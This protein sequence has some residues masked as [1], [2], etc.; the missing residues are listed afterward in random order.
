MTI[1]AKWEEIQRKSPPESALILYTMAG[2]PTLERSLEMIQTLA[3]CG[4]DMIEVGFPFSDPVADGPAIQ[5]ASAKALEQKI[6]LSKVFQGIRALHLSIP[7]LL[8]SYLNPLLA[9]GMERAVKEAKQAGFSGFIIPD[10]PVEEAGSWQ[11]ILK[12]HGMDLVLL[13]APTSSESRLQ[14]IAQASTGFIYAVSL[15]GTTGARDRLP[16]SVIPF[17]RKLKRLS[18][19]PVAVGF[20]ISTPE[21]V[22]TLARIAD[23]V[24]VGSRL[25]HA[26]QKGEPIDLLVQNLKQATIHN[27]I[28]S[29]KAKEVR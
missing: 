2:F 14:S 24:I 12:A 26:I 3:R 1:Q 17:L 4:A 27:G 10:L 11:Q 6:T 5:W 8:M 25:I 28:F 13:A 29:K 23:G 18:P 20:G 15:T 7:L 22:N 19:K 16:S 21:Q 9:F